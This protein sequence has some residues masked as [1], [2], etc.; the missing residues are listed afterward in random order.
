M[1]QKIIS[2]SLVILV[3]ALLTSCDSGL[4]SS[5]FKTL[6]EAKKSGAIEKG[7]LPDFLPPSA[8]DIQETHHIELN[9]I[10]VEFSFAKDDLS[11]LKLFSEVD[12]S[13]IKNI[14]KELYLNGWSKLDNKGNLRV[15][16]RNDN[17]MLGSLAVDFALRRVQYW[18]TLVASKDA[19]KNSGVPRTGH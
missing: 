15:F 16:L 11:F 17:E 5:H 6:E 1:P 4:T 19:S 3:L 13:Q 18:E 7:W 9:R 8:T 2:L 14:L 12:G 10:R